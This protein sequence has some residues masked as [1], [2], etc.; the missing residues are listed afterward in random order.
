MLEKNT[1]SECHNINFS[2]CLALLLVARSVLM[3]Q[4]KSLKRAFWSPS[5]DLITTWNSWL[6]KTNGNFIK[7]FIVRSA[8]SARNSSC[9]KI[10]FHSRHILTLVNVA[11]GCEMEKHHW[12]SQVLC[13]SL[14]D[15]LIQ[16]WTHRG[17]DH[18]HWSGDQWVWAKTRGHCTE[19]NCL[20]SYITLFKV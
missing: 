11:F 9:V 2:F 5:K 10:M 3:T 1:H 7:G 20:S 8:S 15:S 19:H 16:I 4:E 13:K 17:L 18:T 6:V 14:A 12:C